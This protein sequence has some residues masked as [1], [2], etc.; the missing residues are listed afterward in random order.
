MLKKI[1]IFGSYAK[2]QQN[3]E[4]DVDIL[5]E[6]EKPTFDNFMELAFFLEDLFGKKVD[7]LTPKSLSPYMKPYVEK[8]VIWCE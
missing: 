7:L 4:S 2:G 6:F 3:E 1:G 5:V 8:E